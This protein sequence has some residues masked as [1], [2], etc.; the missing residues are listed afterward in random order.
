MGYVR[1]L[2][3]RPVLVLWLS[4]ALS[5]LGDRLYG[6]AVMWV[7]YEATGSASLM[8]LVAVVESAP[9]IALGGAGRLM[10]RCADWRRL[11]H[12]DAARGAVAVAVPLLWS[13]D[14]TG[15]AVLL[16]QVLLLGTLGA[17]FDPSLTAL[18]PELVEPKDVQQVSALFDLTT[19][20]AAVAGPG[21]VGVLLLVVSDI[22]LFALD[23]A[24]FAVS[25][26]ALGWLGRRAVA[27]AVPGAAGS[28]GRRE[29][30][31][32]RPVLRAHPQVGIAI[33]VHA[34][35]M[36]VAAVSAVGLPALL[37]SRMGQTAAGYGLALGATAAGAL[38]GNFLVGRL[39]EHWP[40]LGTYCAA[41]AAAGITLA[42][43]S[44]AS[45]LPAVLALNAAS[46]LVIPVSAVA[47][48]TRLSRFPGP[49]RLRLLTVDQT[50]IRT[51]GTAGMLILP[52]AVDTAPAKTFA[53]AGT[54]L[55]TLAVTGWWVGERTADAPA[56][57]GVAHRA[58][59]HRT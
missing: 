58:A 53:G 14:R 42:A 48:R 15:F 22:E 21:S 11:A 46:G 6:L 45:S 28:A 55:C 41:W 12:L 1:L 10:E 56:P 19:R 5:A 33:A 29:A 36:F 57:D 3:R 23:G 50:A 35:G 43:L 27:S 18:V 2:R 40:W 8:G 44:L 16:V 39:P 32:A 34:G 31:R 54:L 59:D 7:V 26:A 20:L 52:L 25:A 47:L 9:Y 38:A 13:P 30:V 17:L 37:A 4:M 49:E 51:A 24:T